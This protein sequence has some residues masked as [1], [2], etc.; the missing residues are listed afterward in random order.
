V[1][2][3]FQAPL[4]PPEEKPVTAADSSAKSGAE[5]VL[6]EKKAEKA[7]IAN[8]TPE[9]AAEPEPATTWRN[10]RWFVSAELLGLSGV[11]PRVALGGGAHVGLELGWLRFFSQAFVFP[12]VA[13]SV[14]GTSSH[15][16]LWGCGVG[17][18]GVF[19]SEMIAVGPCISG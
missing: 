19:G 5:K 3:D 15:F 2:S 14:A 17:A 12:A 8:S 16:W 4:D 6:A 11:M 10:P 9:I 7:A 18:C 13:E 1:D